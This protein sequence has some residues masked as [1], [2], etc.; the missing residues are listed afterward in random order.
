M[1]KRSGLVLGATR[2]GPQQ[3]TGRKS[4][5]TKAKADA[6]I[7]VLADTCNVTLAAK[8]IERS[9]ANIYKQRSKDATFRSQW[10]QALAVGYSRLE[11]ML[12]E[13]ALHGVEK[14]V[15]ARDGTTSVMRE[16]PD[17][18]ALTLLRMH[19]ETATMAELD[20][21]PDEYREV[22]D[23]IVTR[24]RRLKAREDGPEGADGGIETKGKE[25]R[26]ALIADALRRA[27]RA[28]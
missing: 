18:V 11:L 5:W 16:Y 9:V 25:G 15:V 14:T 22:C 2:N 7:Q 17:R 24:L 3:R 13:R 28:A 4:D 6:F 20:M 10:D 23:R 27:R 8:A 19:R 21:G 1:G 26:I 12:L